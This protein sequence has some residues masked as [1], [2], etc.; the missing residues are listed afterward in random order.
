MNLIEFGDCREIMSRWE[1]EGVRVQTCITSPPYFGLRDY[2]HEGQI[3][4]EETVDDYVAAIVDVF[5]RVKSILADDGTL[6]LNLG[7]SYY[8]YRPGKGQSLVKQTVSNTDQHL[9]QNCARRGNKQA[10]LKEKD[11]IGTHWR[12]AFALQAD[13]WYL[14]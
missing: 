3:G 7:D 1:S 4:L 5:K 2:G 10:G 11:L 9:T 13:G 12:V 8:N 6:W 14:R